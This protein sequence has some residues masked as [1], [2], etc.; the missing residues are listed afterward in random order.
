MP[1]LDVI[2][3]RVGDP[4]VMGGG[5]AG[6]EEAEIEKAVVIQGGMMSGAPAVAF[7]IRLPD[8]GLAFAQTSAAILDAVV[9]AAKGVA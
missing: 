7:V 9:G 2:I 1:E 3:H 8:G 5:L 4:P 6:I